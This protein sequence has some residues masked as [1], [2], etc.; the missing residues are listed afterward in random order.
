MLDKLKGIEKRYAEINQELM[1]VGE[2]Y[3]RATELGKERADIEPLVEKAKEYRQVL[4][5][6]EDAKAMI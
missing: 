4:A 5:G 3:K 1:E 6:L 2:N